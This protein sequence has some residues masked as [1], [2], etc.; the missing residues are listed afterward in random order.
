MTCV[1]ESF[2]L[3]HFVVRTANATDRR[4][5]Q[6]QYRTWLRINYRQVLPRVNPTLVEEP[7]EVLGPAKTAMPS[8]VVVYLDYQRGRV[9]PE[10]VIR[11]RGL[12]ELSAYEAIRGEMVP[13]TNWADGSLRSSFQGVAV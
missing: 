13:M 12:I 1:T 3:P 10:G 6:T 2:L 8:V 4:E 7:P 5:S 11:T 9:R